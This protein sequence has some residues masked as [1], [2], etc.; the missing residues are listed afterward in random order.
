MGGEPLCLLEGEGGGLVPDGCHEGSVY[1]TYLHGLLDEGECCSALVAALLARKGLDAGFVVARDLD[2][3]REEQ[4][5]LLA[6]VVR[7]NMDMRLVY[8][9]LER[10][11]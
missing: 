2:A 11:I 8:E 1:G 10:G 7:E 5:D 4:I 9:I 6:S 3:Y